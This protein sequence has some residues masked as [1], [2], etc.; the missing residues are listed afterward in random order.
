[1]SYIQ[2]RR[3]EAFFLKKYFLR[4]LLENHKKTQK[5]RFLKNSK[6]KKET[7]KN[8][9]KL[10]ISSSNLHNNSTVGKHF[11]TSSEFCNFWKI[12]L[13]AC[14]NFQHIVWRSFRNYCDLIMRRFLGK[15]RNSA[16]SAV[17]LT[18]IISK[19]HGSNLPILFPYILCWKFKKCI[20]KKNYQRKHISSISHL[21]KQFSFIFVF[22]LIT[23]TEFLYLMKYLL[24]TS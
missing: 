22:F 19:F 24:R 1:M 4:N 9:P 5:Q 21:Q 16:H 11:R 10:I 15:K 23:Y 7:A 12:E 2:N 17:Q 14:W 6:K 8:F 20:S 13:G 3:E 18:F